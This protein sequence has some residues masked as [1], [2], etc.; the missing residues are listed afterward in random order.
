MKVVHSF[1]LFFSL[2]KRKK[3]KKIHENEQVNFNTA[4]RMSKKTVLMF[5]GDMKMGREERKKSV[6]IVF[7]T[8]DS[9]TKTN[10]P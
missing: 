5:L 9:K 6:F 4:E 1:C 10:F 8:C 2:I 3:K 7:V